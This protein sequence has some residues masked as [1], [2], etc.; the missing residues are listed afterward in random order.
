M[1][2]VDL[3]FSHQHEGFNQRIVMRALIHWI[4][5]E[6]CTDHCHLNTVELSVVSGD[7]FSFTTC[8]DT[9]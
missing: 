5:L 3:E 9:V 4:M 6:H 1:T 7:R 8:T 2:R